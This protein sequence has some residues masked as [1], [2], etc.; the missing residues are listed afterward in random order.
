MFEI[1]TQ[2]AFIGAFILHYV[3]SLDVATVNVVSSS[4]PVGLENILTVT[5]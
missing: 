1:E 2:T 3:L 5:S 4:F